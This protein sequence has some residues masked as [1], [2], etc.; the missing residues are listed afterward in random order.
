MVP[1]MLLR[2]EKT[3]RTFISVMFSGIRRLNKSK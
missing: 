1:A 2:L 3:D